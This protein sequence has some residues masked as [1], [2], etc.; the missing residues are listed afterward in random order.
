M[1][2]DRHRSFST[3]IATPLLRLSG[4]SGAQSVDDIETRTAVANL[5]GRKII[6]D[7]FLAFVRVHVLHHAA[8]ERIFGVEMMEELSRHGYDVG[9]GTLYPLLHQLEKVGYLTSHPEVVGGKQRKY[10]RV[11]PEGAAALDAAKGKLR[12]L[13]SEVLHDRP[14][15]AVLKTDRRRESG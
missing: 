7:V 13:V 2:V 10:Y 3:I 11:T 15:K 14:A 6:R 9:A 4:R 5:A 8:K 1:D 12:E